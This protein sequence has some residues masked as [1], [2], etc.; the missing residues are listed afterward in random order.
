M[1]TSM[2]IL[3]DHA[4]DSVGSTLLW[5]LLLTFPTLIL[6]P[7]VLGVV[8]YVLRTRWGLRRTGAMIVLAVVVTIFVPPVLVA[9][10]PAPEWGNG[11]EQMI[12]PNL[13]T[14][15]LSM[16]VYVVGVAGANSDAAEAG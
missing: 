12:F 6:V 14:F 16:I 10:G 13:A 1:M 8:S 7:F 11:A 9:L 15:V 2:A 5:A 4:N 3:A